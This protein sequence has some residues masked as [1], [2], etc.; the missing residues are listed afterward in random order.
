MSSFIDDNSITSERYKKIRELADEMSSIKH[1]ALHQALWGN[2][3]QDQ[4]ENS[5]PD[6]LKRLDALSSN[7]QEMRDAIHAEM[8]AGDQRRAIQEMKIKDTPAARAAARKKYG[9]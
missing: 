2:L 1:H 5:Y 6:L 7:V 4:R 9:I 8:N 3:E